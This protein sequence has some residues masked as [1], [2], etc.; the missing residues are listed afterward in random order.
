MGPAP[1]SDMLV[2]ESMKDYLTVESEDGIFL[3]CTE[4]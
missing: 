1:P 4:R 3:V 2:D